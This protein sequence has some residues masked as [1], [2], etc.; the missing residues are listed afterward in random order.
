[1]RT[2]LIIASW[3]LGIATVALLVAF[4]SVSERRTAI[5]TVNIELNQ[6]QNQLFLNKHIAMAKPKYEH[7]QGVLRLRIY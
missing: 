1:M 7:L 3:V 6:P 5:T 2:A 4:E